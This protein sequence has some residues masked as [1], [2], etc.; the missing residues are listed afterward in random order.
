MVHVLYAVT[1]F[2]C[3]L[4]AL[5]LPARTKSRLSKNSS[6]DRAFLFLSVWI[7]I[8]CIADGMWGIFASHLIPNDQMLFVS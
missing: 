7:V 5:L 1:A 4:V 8:F 3:A 2:A 6:T